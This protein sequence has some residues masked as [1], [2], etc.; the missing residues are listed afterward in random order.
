M[1]GFIFGLIVG[2]VGIIVAAYFVWKK[3]K[4]KFTAAVK[5]ALEGPGTP[6]EKIK[7]ILEIIKA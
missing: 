6:E 3:N 2:A 1:T 7:K 4:A 5:E